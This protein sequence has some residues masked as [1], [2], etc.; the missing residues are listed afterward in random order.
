[1]KFCEGERTSSLCSCACVICDTCY[2][3]D[4]DVSDH[5]DGSSVSEGVRRVF[6]SE[7]LTPT[8]TNEPDY[9]DI[10]VSFSQRVITAHKASMHVLF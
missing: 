4:C 9:N 5:T 1:M 2:N 7:Y 10:C 8:C 3:E 6:N